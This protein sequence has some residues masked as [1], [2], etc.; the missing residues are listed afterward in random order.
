[1]AANKL[2]PKVSI[3]IPVY[4]GSDYLRSAINSALAQSYENIEVVVVNDGSSDGG[5]TD[6]IAK[7]YGDRIRYYKKENGGVSTALNLAIEKMQGEYFSW[8][9]HDDLYKDNK[10]QSQI[11]FL[12]TLEDKNSIIY[13][14]FELINE[15]GE[16]LEKCVNNHELLERV[17]VYALLR[18]IINGITM[19]IP[20]KAFKTHGKFDES[21]KCAQDY[22]MWFRLFNDYTFVHQQ[23]ILTQ[24]RIH[25]SQ[26]TTSNPAA[27]TEGNALW[28]RMIK[29]IDNVTKQKAEGNLFTFY[30]EMVKFLKNTPYNEALEYCVRELERYA[31]SKEVNSD[32]YRTDKVVIQTANSLIDEDQ[33]I[34]AA[35]FTSNILAQ[36]IAKKKHDRS[37]DII[38]GGLVGKLKNVDSVHESEKY[39][40]KAIANKKKKRILFCSGYWLT[41]G[42]ERVLSILFEQL[43]D[44]YEIF[45]VTPHDGRKSNITVPPHVNHI[46]ISEDYYTK[47]DSITLT[48]AI[49]LKIDVVIGMNWEK[50]QLLLYDMCTSVGIKT[51][52]SNHEIYFYPYLN[53]NLQGLINRRV[54]VF[55]NVD[56]VLWPTNFSAAAYGLVANNSYLMPNPNTYDIKSS[57]KDHDENIILC[58]G[59]FTDYVKRIDR[60]LHC[61]SEVSKNV[62]NAK[63]ILVG[64]YDNDV[65]FMPADSRTVNHLLKEYRI[66]QSRVEFVGEVDNLDEYYAKASLLLVTSNNEGFCMVVN[67]AACYGVPTVCNRIPGLEDLINN[68]EN[69]YIV[70]QDDIVALSNK[71]ETLLADKELRNRTGKQAKEY[72]KKFS[73]ETV[74]NSWKYLINTVITEKNTDKALRKKLDYKIE[75]YRAYSKLLMREMDKIVA[76]MQSGPV[77]N[78]VA[79]A[80]KENENLKK[81]VYGLSSDLNQI[82]NSKRWVVT[83]RII[84]LTVGKAR[85]L[86]S[87]RGDA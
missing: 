77:R 50:E 62:P 22:D 10:I 87:K 69:G 4:N 31:N 28:I 37:I 34:S 24:T 3:I 48:Y 29:Q 78:D 15:H 18:G 74:G 9:S 38:K 72:V 65:E 20:A 83:S 2:N 19:L 73:K 79:S 82:R 43:K 45:L 40:T 32:D 71:V 68:G 84:D 13:A 67:E 46:L 33:K 81:E 61:F 64:K 58:V 7:S 44:E 86:S 16:L 35:Y 5:A 17:P 53:I 66:D 8:L 30:F 14:D 1:M 55:K 42:I 51:I 26:G 47:Y 39:L 60:I 54:E 23:E 70:E 52:A 21:M 80:R 63:L 56:A 27:T 6:K 57:Y 75:D 41:G 36:L 12:N 49:M 85:R 25:S 59:R 11:D 76:M